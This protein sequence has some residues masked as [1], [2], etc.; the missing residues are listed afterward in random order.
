M[1]MLLIASW[2]AVHSDS[3]IRL[4]MVSSSDWFVP[5]SSVNALI[6][7]FSFAV[8]SLKKRREIMAKRPRQEAKAILT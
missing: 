5:C 6:S 1:K 2:R 8:A 3:I 4:M 7:L